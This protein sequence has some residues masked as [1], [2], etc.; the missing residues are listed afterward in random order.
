MKKLFDKVIEDCTAALNVDSGYT[1]ALMRRAKA[2]ENIDQLQEAF[3]DLT[4]LC[5][6]DKFSA[7]AMASADKMVK[8][9]G[10][11][12]ASEKFKVSISA[13]F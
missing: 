13:R 10:Q 12:M 2:Y 1:K 11:K 4:K 8:K 3:E 7:T 5:I 6:L 9:I